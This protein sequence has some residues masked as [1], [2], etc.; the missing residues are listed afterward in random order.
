MKQ[1]PV[2]PGEACENHRA[3]AKTLPSNPKVII[4]EGGKLERYEWLQN[5]VGNCEEY[6]SICD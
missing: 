5:K 6:K 1:L 2:S 4:P 3:A